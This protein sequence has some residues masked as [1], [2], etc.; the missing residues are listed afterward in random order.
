VFDI[1]V[2]KYQTHEGFMHKG[3]YLLCGWSPIL[4]VCETHSSVKLL[5]PPDDPGKYLITVEDLETGRQGTLHP[6]AIQAIFG[7]HWRPP[8]KLTP[9]FG[10]SSH[11]FWRNKF[12]W[13]LQGARN[14][15]KNTA[16]INIKYH[17]IHFLFV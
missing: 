12:K 13:S 1:L 14:I 4:A 9:S 11:Q 3:D 8:N 15:I 10:A 17:S 2:S 6:T 7:I 5:Y 16:Q